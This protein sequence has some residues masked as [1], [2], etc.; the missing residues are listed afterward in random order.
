MCYF[1]CVLGYSG[2][3]RGREIS[4]LDAASGRNCADRFERPPIPRAR[5]LATPEG[6]RDSFAATSLTLSR[7][8]LPLLTFFSRLDLLRACYL[9]TSL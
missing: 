3:R 4:Q 8:E 5:A 7:G 6:K 2:Q 9:V 1:S